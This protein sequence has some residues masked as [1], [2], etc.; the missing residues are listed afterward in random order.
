M[1]YKMTAERR[2]ELKR[3]VTQGAVFSF[4]TFVTSAFFVVPFWALGFPL[5]FAAGIFGASIAAG[6]LF[7]SAKENL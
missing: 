3:T 5:D 6:F 4:M 7:K 2:D 1:T